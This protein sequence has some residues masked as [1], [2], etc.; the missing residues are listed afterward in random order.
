MGRRMKSGRWLMSK[1]Q[2]AGRRPI[3]GRASDPCTTGE[4]PAPS[5]SQAAGSCAVVR[6]LIHAR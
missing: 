2:A 1:D 3:D 6:S 4:S 5:R